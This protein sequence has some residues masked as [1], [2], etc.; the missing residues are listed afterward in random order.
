MKKLYYLLPIGL[1]LLIL[2]GFEMDD[3][4]KNTQKAGKKNARDGDWHFKICPKISS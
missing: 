4:D 3:K 2:F 1:A